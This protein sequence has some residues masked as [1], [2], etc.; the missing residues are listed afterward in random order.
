MWTKTFDIVGNV[1]IKEPYFFPTYL[2]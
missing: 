2:W 1:N